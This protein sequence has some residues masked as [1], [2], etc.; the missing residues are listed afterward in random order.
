VRDRV[1]AVKAV[2]WVLGLV[3]ATLIVVDY[4]H[5]R[6]GANPIEESTG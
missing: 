4:L 6:L 3:P 1:R 2:I 5:G